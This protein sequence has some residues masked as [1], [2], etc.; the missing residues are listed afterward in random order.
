MKPSAS[1]MGRAAVCPASHALP[2]AE[3]QGE[4]ARDG[5]AIHAYLA[6]VAV[7]PATK[8]V[9]LQDV[10]EHLRARCAAIDVAGAL[11]GLGTIVTEPAY[12]LDV[13]EG[14]TRY[15][16]ENIGRA[17]GELGRTEIACT[18]DVLGWRDDVPVVLDWKTGQDVGDVQENWQM[19]IQALVARA[20]SMGAHEVEARICYIGEDGS[21]RTASHVFDA[22]EL[23]AAEDELREI[24]ARVRKAEE[25]YKAG[26]LPSMAEGD[27]CKY[28]PSFAFCPAKVSLAR[29]MVRDVEALTGQVEALTL[30][31]KGE[32]WA[33]LK[34]FFGLAR[35]IE[36]V[37]KDEARRADVPLPNG[38]VLRAVP[39]TR[40]TVDGKRALVMLRELGVDDTVL[41]TL[42]TA[43]PYQTIREVKP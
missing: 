24:L 27:H 12:A 16:G 9:A 4:P 30:A 28:C 13:A 19:R 32:V 33:K 41:S 23:D 21:T 36:D 26:G 3:S 10:P 34:Q 29:A 20:A 7:S 18:L 8:S 17:Y 1:S 11:N 38:K 5:H 40:E 15:I 35:R 22:F 42:T 39:G 6:R 31:E 14:T 37:I 2:R 25:V 43:T